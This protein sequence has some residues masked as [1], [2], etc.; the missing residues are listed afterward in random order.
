MMTAV[1]NVL[2]QGQAAK[3]TNWGLWADGYLGMGNRRSDEL[4]AKYRQNLF[5]G[6]IGF[7]YRVADDLYVGI[8]G[9]ISRTN[10]EFDDLPD[11]GHMDSYQGSLYLC[12]NGKPWYAAGV[13]TYAYNKYDL[14]RYITTLGPTMIANSDYS[15]NEYTGYAEV[16]YKISAGNVEIRPLAAFQVDYLEQESFTET[17]AG[18]YNLSVEE[19]ETGSY[20]S[21]LGVN[22]T[23]NI[24]LSETAALRPE[25][26]LKWAHEFSN[27][28][29]MINAQFADMSS[30]SFVVEAETLSRDTAIIGVGM[31]L[32]FNKHVGAY[33]HYD[34]E[35]NSDFVNHTGL[36]G[37]RLVW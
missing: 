29:H 11:E 16:G 10:V 33:I 21:F 31:S 23:G 37:L 17:G 24:K 26:R 6:I 15:G 8:S 20:K 19:Q 35:L 4:I 3:G 32:L 22:V 2:S 25:F 18:S 34:A 5:G 13:F 7:D 28:D 30:G 1:G 27:D 12:Y 36:L 9:G 14:D